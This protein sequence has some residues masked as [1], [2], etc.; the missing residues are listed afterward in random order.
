VQDEFVTM[1]E[2]QEILGVSRFKIWQLVRDGELETFEYPLD[3]RQKLIRRSDLDA[4]RSPKPRADFG[5]LKKAA[6]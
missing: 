5:E 3:R 4:L 6:A 1:T 2:A